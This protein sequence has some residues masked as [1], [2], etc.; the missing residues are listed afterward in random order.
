MKNELKKYYDQKLRI[1]KEKLKI[2]RKRP[3]DREKKTIGRFLTKRKM[4][5]SLL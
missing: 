3:I 1:K 4:N 2:C 5:I